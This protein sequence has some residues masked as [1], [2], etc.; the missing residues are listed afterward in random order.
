MNTFLRFFYEFI[1]IFIDGLLLIVTGFINGIRQIVNYKDYIKIINS[2]K[3][4]FENSEWFFVALSIAVIVIIVGLIGLLIYF[5]IRRLIRFR[6]SKVEQEELLN[7]IANL[8][9]QVRNLVKEKEKIM[10]MKVS[11]LGLR[12][13]EEEPPSEEE[14][15]KED[16]KEA[17]NIRFPKLNKIDEEYKAYKIRNYG[18]NFTL[19]ELLDNFRCFAASQLRLYYDEKILRAFIGGLAC[20][21]LIILQGISGTGKTSLAYAWGKFVNRDSCIASVQPSWRDKT[22]LLGYFNEFTKKFNETDVLA[23]LYIAGHTDDVHTII[24]DEMNIARVEYY[25]AEML[26]IMEMPTRDEWIVEL[27]TSSW[28]D[29]PKRIVGG[30]LRLPGNLWYIGTINNDDSTFMVTDKVYDRAMPIDINTKIEPFK[31]REQESISINASYLESLFAKAT[32]EKPVDDKNIEKIWQMDEYVIKHFRIAFGNRIMKQLNIFVPVYVACG[33]DEI[34]A[35]DYFIAKKIFRKFDQLNIS[36]IRD[37][38]DPFIAYLNKNFGNGAM[39]ECIDY[40]E[41]LKKTV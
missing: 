23:E 30:K 41:R 15:N 36:L 32:E 11:K 2:Y 14:E 33:G 1:S 35:I 31:S 21:K 27:V 29:D 26:S 25:F 40:L 19:D 18:N 24:L 3:D 10:A 34:E 22:E 39:V 9:N 17:G 20:S 4:S 37:E 6:K 12:P 16:L 5:G 8:N 7:E 13:D 28:P 38:I